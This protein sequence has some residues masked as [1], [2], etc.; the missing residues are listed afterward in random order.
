MKN[1]IKL[2]E[3]EKILLVNWTKFIDTHRFITF[4]LS[5]IN[6]ANL[7]ISDQKILENRESL[8]I[9]LSQFKL[10]SNYKFI[11]WAD[12]IIPKQEGIAFG[13]CEIN[14]DIL[15]N[16]LTHLQ[17]TGNIFSY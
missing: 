5:N 10:D 12:F 11:I 8:K 6:N 9:T 1:L 3:L 13:T 2:D 16:E 15:N 14:L 17:T 4:I 7:M